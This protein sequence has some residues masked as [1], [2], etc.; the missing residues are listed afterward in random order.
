[1]IL[2]IGGAGFIGSN[3]AAALQ[4]KGHA[5]AVSDWLG[6]GDKWRNL[7]KREVAAGTAP[8]Q[9]PDLLK[10]HKN[11]IEAVF[12]MGAISTTPETNVDLIL[13]TNFRLSHT[14]SHW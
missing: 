13:K 6:T 3:L 4:A 7:A 11:K 12:H 1:M 9:L 8:E 5:L 10:S 14:L 2:I